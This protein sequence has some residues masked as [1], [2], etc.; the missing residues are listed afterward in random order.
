MDLVQE[1]GRLITTSEAWMNIGGQ[2]CDLSTTKREHKARVI[3]H[4]TSTRG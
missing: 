3:V 4:T 1:F 2:I